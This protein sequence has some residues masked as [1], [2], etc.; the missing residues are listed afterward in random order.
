MK[1]HKLLSLILFLFA[2][3]TL[4]Q[5][6]WDA[7]EIKAIKVNDK[8]SYLEGRGGNIGVLHGQD[9]VMI[10]D[11]QYE[12]LSEKINDALEAFGS[13]D[14]KFILNTHYHGDHTGGNANLGNDA[15]IVAQENVRK[16][17]GTDFYN[18]VF[19]RETMAKPESYWPEITFRENITLFFN[20]EEIELTYLPNAHTDGDA[21]VYFKTS[22]ILHAGDCFVR[23]GYPFIDI[24]AG[25]TIDGM[26]NAQEKILEITNEE[27]KI[28]P[29]HG[30]IATKDDVKELLKMLKECREIIDDMK[31]DGKSLDDCITA[32]PLAEY[33]ER[34]NGSFINSDLFVRLIYESL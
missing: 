14:L 26:I 23:Y 15:W 17:L 3:S 6:D 1:M 25:G 27:T 11:D 12:Q 4:A 33:H 21:V 22:N 2:I 5:T 18:A 19:D 32:Q 30:G 34:W 31:E 16:R 7:V 28:I 8:I 24:S 13:G 20:G 29:G 9:G 10:V